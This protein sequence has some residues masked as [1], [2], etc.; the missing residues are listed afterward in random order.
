[1]AT[2][3]DTLLVRIESD[4]SG[5]RR[6]LQRLERQTNAS[7]KRVQ[8]NFS[9]MGTAVK[10]ALGV[11]AV[12]II[13]RFIAANVKL[14]S[15]VEEMQSKSSVVFGSFVEGVRADLEEFG[16]AVGRS[17]HEL[18]GMASSV[19]DTFVPLGFARGEAADLSVA[20]TKL[21]VDVASF[22]NASDTDTMQAF[23]SALVGNHEA[24]RRFGI[25][26]TEAELQAELFRM[27]INKN[28]KDVDAATKVQA[29]LNLIMNG[30]ADAQGDAERTAGSFA[31]RSKALSAALEELLVNVMTPLLPVL[32]DFVGKVTS[33][34]N[35]LNEFLISTNLLTR[36][37]TVQANVLAQLAIKQAELAEQ[38]D[39]LANGNNRQQ[40]NARGAIKVLNDEIAVLE[41]HKAANDRKLAAQQANN[42]AGKNSNAITQA[43]QEAN[44]E[45]VKQLDQMANANK[46]LTMQLQ[47]R[48]EAEMRLEELRQKARLG[49]AEEQKAFADNEKQF[50]KLMEEQIAKEE[51]LK[52]I[53]DAQQ[54]AASAAQEFRSEEDK[55]QERI[56]AVSAAMRGASQEDMVLYQQALDGLQLKLK[57][58]DPVFK[59]FKEAAE[60]AADSVADSLADS[61]IDGKLSL[62]SL[63]DI[64]RDFV[65]QIIK[66]AIKTFIVRQILNTAFMGFGGG[67]S[68]GMG[69]GGGSLPAG[70]TTYAA[71]AKGGR[72]PARASGGPVLVGER[73]PELFIPNSAG[74][75]RNNHDTLNM[76]RGGNQPVVN[77][78]INVTTGVAQTVRAEV[79]SMMPRIKQETI[80]AMI[81]GKK[82]GNAVAKAFG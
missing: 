67:G 79:M 31:N 8:S 38:Q 3:V 16:D 74:V 82:R 23:Q 64:F 15:S 22:N 17:T 41:A 49:T 6:D 57:E 30:T 2:T 51:A 42:N 66:E 14:A 11:A 43:Q 58:T 26:I 69:S 1:M 12:G 81:D 68:V 13:G 4:M 75:I 55:L 77:Q 34:V 33:G 25:V 50:Q 32:A 36:D 27:G 39:I 45:V 47:G 71:F 21:A 10:A 60:S 59:A 52:K 78:T 19:Q 62:D 70:D 73:G 35:A 40:R 5:I 48:T 76:M 63:Q 53:T 37:M 7:S 72:I 61:V 29:R 24:V 20:L 44:A 18:E 65:K 54:M 28:S 80:G 56:D 9:K 46:L